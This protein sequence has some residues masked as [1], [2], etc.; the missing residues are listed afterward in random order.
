MLTLL[1]ACDKHLT[2]S[3]LR[4]EGFVW[5]HSVRGIWWRRH[6]SR[7]MISLSVLC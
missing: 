5:T 6:G 3:N 2:S 7:H 1:S 4:Q